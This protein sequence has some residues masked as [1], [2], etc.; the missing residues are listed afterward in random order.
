MPLLRSDGPYIELSV[1]PVAVGYGVA[2]DGSIPR[3]ALTAAEFTELGNGLYALLATFDGYLAAHVG[4]DPEGVVDPVEL[5]NEWMDELSDGAID[6]LVL[7]DGLHAEFGLGSNYGVFQPGFR[8]IPSRG[9]TP[10]TL[11]AD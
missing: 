10:S 8:W 6:G 4:W 7:C 9:H 1:L 11:T 2:L 3:L 5:S